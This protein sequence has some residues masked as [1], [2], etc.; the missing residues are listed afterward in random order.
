GGG[1]AHHLVV[2]LLEHQAQPLP[3][4]RRV[5][6]DQDPHGITASTRVPLPAGDV[7]ASR[8]SRAATRPPTPARPPPACLAAP[9]RPSSPILP[10]SSSPIR[11]SSTRMARAPECLAA[12]VRDSE[13]T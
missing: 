7:T 8:P 12:L 6:G 2:G 13:T 4:Q 3:D 9:P 1:G 11:A 5:V 10:P